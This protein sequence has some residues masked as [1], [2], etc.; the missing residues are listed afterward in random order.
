MSMKCIGYLLASVSFSFA[1]ASC[2]GNEDFSDEQF[3]PQTYN[4]QGKVE[5]GPFI[6]GSEISIQPMDAK[7]QVLGSMFNTSITDDLGNFVLGSKEFSTPYV[8]FIANGYFFNEVKGELSNGT[9]TLRAL[10]D[11]K[12]NTTV[13]VNVLT[14]L[15][16]AR[17]INL[18]ASGKRFDEAKHKRSYWMPLD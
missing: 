17:I 3:I 18:V 4:V 13:N 2:S 1:M 14:H 11:L 16:Y 15:K 12:D 8:E 5:K 10:V 6:S 9:L 7:L